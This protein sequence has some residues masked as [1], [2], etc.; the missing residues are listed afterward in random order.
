[1]ERIKITLEFEVDYTQFHDDIE[2]LRDDF[3]GGI[4]CCCVNLPYEESFT[5]TAEYPNGDIETM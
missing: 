5:I 1:M 3:Y 2:D 4:S